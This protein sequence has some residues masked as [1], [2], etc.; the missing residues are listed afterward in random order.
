MTRSENAPE[1]DSSLDW[2]YFDELSNDHDRFAPDHTFIVDVAHPIPGVAR[3]VSMTK[4]DGSGTAERWFCIL[5][6]ELPEELTPVTWLKW[7]NAWLDRRAAALADRTPEVKRILRITINNATTED[8]DAFIRLLCQEFPGNQNDMVPEEQASTELSTLSQKKDEDIYTYYRRTET[9]LIGISGRDQ[10]THN[11]ENSIILNNAKQHI[12][13]DT[14]AK[15]G[16][17]LKI[18]ELCLH[19]IEYKAD[20]MRSLYGAFK[21]AEIYLDVSNAKAQMQKELELKSGYG[22][23]KSFQATVAS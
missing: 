14:I 8:K 21:K 17:G 19:M 20:P 4:F 16:F 1:L 18:S 23:F 22:A 9:L 6:K 12:L 5:K 3:I 2:C 10:V 13:K 11:G 15:F 7:A